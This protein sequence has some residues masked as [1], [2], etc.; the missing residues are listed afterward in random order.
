MNHTYNTYDTYAALQNFVNK[1]YVWYVLYVYDGLSNI[2][3][4][5]RIHT[6]WTSYSNRIQ[7]VLY[8]ILETKWIY[9]TYD[10]HV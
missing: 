7:R 2:W 6:L 3:Q 9:D 8:Y 10:I 4:T 5:Q 1:S